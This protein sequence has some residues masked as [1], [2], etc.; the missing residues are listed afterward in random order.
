MSIALRGV[1]RQYGD[2][3]AVENIDLTVETGALLALLGPSGSG[4]TTLL[5]IIAGL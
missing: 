1:T 3:A 2:F 4:K 5:R